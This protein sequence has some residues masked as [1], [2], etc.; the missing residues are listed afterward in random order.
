MKLHLRFALAVLAV[1]VL[2]IMAKQSAV[3]GIGGVG[4]QNELAMQWKKHVQ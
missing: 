1:G 3:V 4:K 2:V